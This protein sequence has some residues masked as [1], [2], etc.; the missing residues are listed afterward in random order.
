MSRKIRHILQVGGSLAIAVPKVWFDGKIYIDLADEDWRV[1]QIGPEGWRV[2]GGKGD[3]PPIL[4]RRYPHMRSIRVGTPNRDAF[5]RYFS[6]IHAPTDEDKLLFRVITP[7]YLIPGKPQLI[8]VIYGDQGGG[9]STIVKLIRALIDPSETLTLSLPSD[10][11]ERA[12]QFQHH[13]VCAYDNLHSITQAESDDIC[14]AVSGDG[15]SKR[16]LYTD[17]DDCIFRFMRGFIVN[18]IN[19]PGQSP[20]F[21]D[22]AIMTRVSRI[23]EEERRDE[24]D[25]W[26]TANELIPD[27]FAYVCETLSRAMKIKPTLKISRLPR[28]ADF[29]LWGEA[30]SRALGYPDLAWMR[31]YWARLDMQNEIAIE[32]DVVGAL[33]QELAKRRNGEWC[34]SATELLNELILIA[35]DLKI[36]TRAKYFP[37]APH[38]LMRRVNILKTNLENVG[39]GV[40]VLQHPITRVR[41][42]HIHLQKAFGAFERSFSTEELANAI[43]KSNAISIRNQKDANAIP[44]AANGISNAISTDTVQGN[45]TSEKELKNTEPSASNA[46]LRKIVGKQK[47]RAEAGGTGK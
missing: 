6:L 4:F 13:F 19:V 16:A 11:R 2:M 21:L 38:A 43:P 24:D 29:A 44:S 8:Q 15:F 34:G 47:P 45:S 35:P 37:K 40:V 26:A 33:L 9:K 20:D 28:M 46:I 30:V 5:E 31:A 39:C 36:D 14:R 1:V 12:Q 32:G 17:D 27:A 25:I 10:R 22:R 42:L 3:N 18:G 7:T 41:Q 23:S